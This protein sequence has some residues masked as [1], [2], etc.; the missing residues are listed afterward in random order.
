M[1]SELVVKT[2]KIPIIAIEFW[3]VFGSEENSEYLRQKKFSFY[4]K[5]T[6][7][8]SPIFFHIHLLPS[9][10]KNRSIHIW[11]ISSRNAIYCFD[12]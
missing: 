4:K 8:N 9:K 1:E 12:K 5:K 6:F 11:F 7:R 10:N 3:M 2:W